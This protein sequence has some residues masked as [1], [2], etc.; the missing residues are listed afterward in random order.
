MA[1][2]TSSRAAR[3]RLHALWRLYTTRGLRRGEGCRLRRPDT[4][5]AAAVTTICWQITQLGWDTT[6]GPPIRRRTTSRFA[7]ACSTGRLI[8]DM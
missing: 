8:T 6:Q 1:R 5:L 4:D 3:H 2:W 7:V